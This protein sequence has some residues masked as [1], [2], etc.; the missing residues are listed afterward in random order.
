MARPLIGVTA[1]LE[2]ARHGVWEELCDLLPRAYASAIQSAGGIAVLLPAD[3]DVARNPDLLLDRLDGLLLAGGGDIDPITYGARPHPRV[4][5]TNEARDRFE[6]ALAH[7]ALER[8]LPVLG[9]CRGMQVLN[10]VTGGTLVQHLPDAVGADRHVEEPGTYSEHRVELEPGS[11]A[12]RV[13]GA[14]ATVVKSH[15]HQGIEE[16]G[17]G[18]RVS[19]RSADD[20]IP[21]AIELPGRTF[22]LGVLWHPEADEASR[23]VGAFVAEAAERARRGE[24]EAVR[25]PAVVGGGGC[26]C[27]GGGCGCGRGPG[28]GHG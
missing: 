8:D 9:I 19:G 5:G 14:D 15:H 6:L 2:T 20:G 17:E 23:V 1:A 11:L 16:L 18:L 21:E 7:R 27:G 12:A 25:E 13:V 24:R 28:F 22:A 10:V 26:G 4:R 3:D